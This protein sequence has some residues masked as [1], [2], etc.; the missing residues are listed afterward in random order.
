MDKISEPE[1]KLVRDL[2]KEKTGI[3]MTDD[4]KSLVYA[5]L[6]N[7][8]IKNN[9]ESFKEYYI[10]IQKK[11]NKEEMT[12]FINRLTTNHTFFNREASH[13]EY[14]YD[15]VLPYI[16]KS[17]SKEKD[18]RLWCAAS[19]SGEEPYNL[20]FTIADFFSND[21]GWDTQILATDISTK[22]LEKAAK[23]IYL[24]EN[25]EDVNP[26]YIKKYMKEYDKDSYIVKDEIKKKIAFR[27]F[28]LTDKPYKFQKKLQVIFCRNVMIYFDNET[29][30]Q[31]LQNMYDS[32]E[33][34]GY[35]F[36]S[37]SE[38]LG[39]ANVGFEYIEP[40]VYRKPF[41]KS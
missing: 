6:K 30:L 13:F 2:I 7:H 21:V 33:E 41:K 8:L 29:K 39:N 27:Q 22:V 35:F 26:E 38:S 15:V 18:L 11:E 23:G 36:V 19:S 24:K 16:K 40:S 32:L 10:F 5:R 17:Y 1:F 20:A 4:K 14:L 12:Y 37:H 9:F 25:C 34:G 28:N 31:V 3:H